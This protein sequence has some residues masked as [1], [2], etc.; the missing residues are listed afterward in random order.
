MQDEGRTDLGRK[1]GR[2]LDDGFDDVVSRRPELI[3]CPMLA[4]VQRP[5][6]HAGAA[7]SGIVWN[8]DGV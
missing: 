1:R 2:R 3:D 7:M 8:E 4:Q 5:S 6:P